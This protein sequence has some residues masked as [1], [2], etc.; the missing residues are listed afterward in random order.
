MDNIYMYAGELRTMRVY[1]TLDSEE[2]F[3]IS[4]PTYKVKYQ[5][6]IIDEGPC[7]IGAEPHELCISLNPENEGRY[8]LTVD[9]W[10]AGEHIIRSHNIYVRKTK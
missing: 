8:T 6:E 4:E 10:V 3:I 2:D 5:D 7:L 1:V 9:F